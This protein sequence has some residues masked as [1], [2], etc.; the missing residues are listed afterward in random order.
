MRLSAHVTAFAVMTR[1][2]YIARHPGHST[3]EWR[4]KE[5]GGFFTRHLDALGE[6]GVIV[7]GSNT[8]ATVRERLSKRNCV[9]FTHFTPSITQVNKKLLLYNPAGASLA[10]VL[11]RYKKVALIG[12]AQTYAYFLERDLID[13]V[14][15][16]VEPVEFG[17][18]LRF[19]NSQEDISTGFQLERK[20]RL[21]SQ[22][23]DLYHYQ[24]KLTRA[25]I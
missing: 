11:G 6:T 19:F 1:D 23:T 2:W 10:E 15:L 17:S 5:D 4:S 21:N 18:G 24:R 20:Q 13:E 14:Y 7:V 12:G 22:G 8:Y 9:V 25:H 3:L 16:T